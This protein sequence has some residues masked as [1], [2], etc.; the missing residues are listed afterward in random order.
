MDILHLIG[1]ISLALLSFW[2]TKNKKSRQ[3]FPVNSR[4]NPNHKTERWIFPSGW[5]L[6]FIMFKSD[7]A[8]VKR[9]FQTC[10]VQGSE[11]LNYLIQFGLHAL[12]FCLNI[13]T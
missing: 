12:S 1:K 13:L 11:N 4:F 6:I 3:T 10:K 2:K 5:K 8:T 7:G 9:V